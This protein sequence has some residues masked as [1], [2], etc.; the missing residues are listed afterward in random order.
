M[1]YDDAIAELV[2]LGQQRTTRELD[3]SRMRTDRQYRPLRPS[4]SCGQ[5]GQRGENDSISRL[6]D[7]M[8]D[9]APGQ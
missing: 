8:N 3:V 1:Q 6:H 5:Q 4:A 9:N 7:A 2:L